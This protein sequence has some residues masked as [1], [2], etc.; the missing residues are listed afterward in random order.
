MTLHG[1]PK[2]QGRASLKKAGRL[3]KRK[4]LLD[5]ALGG[6]RDVYRQVRHDIFAGSVMKKHKTKKKA[7]GASSL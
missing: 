1:L 4:P 2:C 6:L 7:E 5:R 3:L